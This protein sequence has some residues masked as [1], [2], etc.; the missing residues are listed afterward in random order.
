MSR[1]VKGSFKKCQNLRVTLGYRRGGNI[2]LTYLLRVACK[3][4]PSFNG[5]SCVR[6]P[7]Q[8]VPKSH[9]ES[10][11]TSPSRPSLSS[12][13]PSVFF[14]KARKSRPWARASPS[15]PRPLQQPG[16]AQW[17][18]V[19]IWHGSP[20]L[21]TSPTDSG[22]IRTQEPDQACLSL[23]RNFPWSHPAV[24]L[25][26]W[27]LSVRPFTVLLPSQARRLCF[28]RVP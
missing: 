26:P 15:E 27:T 25:W 17:L 28:P 22:A 12:V 21:F 3:L 5:E 20:E 9:E 10:L 24:Q 8:Q 1:I 18:T 2:I 13:P 11:G 6:L 14:S 16:P 7:G 4:E 19:R 23:D